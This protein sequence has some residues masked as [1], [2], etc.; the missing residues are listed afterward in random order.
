LYILVLH[1]IEKNASK[2]ALQLSHIKVQQPT[3]GTRHSACSCTIE[4]G[5]AN[6]SKK[7]AVTMQIGLRFV[8]LQYR[9]WQAN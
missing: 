5:I 6:K 4:G 7:F 1:N 2:F 9:K 8:Q 3:A